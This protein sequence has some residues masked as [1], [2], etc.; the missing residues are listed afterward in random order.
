MRETR[1]LEAVDNR[2]IA[3]YARKSKLTETGKSME[4]QVLRCMRYAQLK[5]DAG[6]EEL[7]VYQDEGLSGFYADRPQY[8]H[9]LR[10]IRDDKIRAV[11][12]YKFDRISRK[13]LDLLNLVEQLRQKKISFISCTDEVDTSSRTGKI[14]MSLLASIAEFERDIIAERITDNLCELAREGRWLGGTTPTGFVSRKEVLAC[15][16]RKTT[17]HRLAP[18]PEEQETVRELFARFLAL[19]SVQSLVEWAGEK[20]IRTKNNRSHTRVSIKNILTNPV[21]AAADRDVFSYFAAHGVSLC[22]GEEAFDGSHGLMAYNKTEQ[23]REL[24]ADSSCVSPRYVQRTQVRDE[25]AW[26]IAIG[27]HEGIVPGR[28]W[29]M[30]QRILQENRDQ[31]LRPKQKTNALLSG[32]IVCPGCG[33]PL[34]THRETGRFTEGKP[35]FRYRCRAKREES[36]CASRSVRGNEADR[37]VLETVCALAAM[38]EDTYWELL[39]KGLESRA[40]SGE[41]GTEH[42]GGRETE[43]KQAAKAIGSFAGLMEHLSEREKTELVR[44][45]VERVYVLPDDEGGETLHIFLKGAGAEIEDAAPCLLGFPAGPA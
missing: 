42:G 45:A 41:D 14:M 7:I 35:R 39:K 3:V 8:L 23:T 28:D 5:F 31:F 4:N 32:I 2:K 1:Q 11:I 20:G 38:G 27:K 25:T 15:N 16:G 44:A 33:K 37:L 6:V 17:V 34:F 24:R 19:R 26:I 21:Y 18:V 13:T 36:A 12:C 10:D 40:G 22:A 9:M 43:L 30:V 29:V